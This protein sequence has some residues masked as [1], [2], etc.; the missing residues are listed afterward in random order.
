MSQ[1][2][3]GGLGFR[4]VTCLNSVMEAKTLGVSCLNIVMEAKTSGVSHVL[5]V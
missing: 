2:C 5:K 1:K 3:D 4:S